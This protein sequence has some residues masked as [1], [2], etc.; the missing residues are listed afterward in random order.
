MTP[1][2]PTPPISR[3]RFL[4]LCAAVL[5]AGALA[6]LTLTGCQEGKRGQHRRSALLLGGHSFAAGMPWAFTWDHGVDIDPRAAARRPLTVQILSPSGDRARRIEEGIAA[7]EGATGGR[8]QVRFIGMTADTVAT[9]LDN[10]PDIFVIDGVSPDGTWGVTIPHC[11][12]TGPLGPDGQTGALD[13]VQIV[14]SRD[15]PWP[16]LRSTATHEFGHALGIG[17]HAPG[18]HDTLYYQA[19]G[20]ERISPDDLA[21]LAAVYGIHP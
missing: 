4:A 18:P 17:G 12:R 3:R 10:P 11:R 6:L 2:T 13:F 21:T 20:V 16:F 9:V 1:T 15:C 7:W 5:L 14:I 8:V 19:N